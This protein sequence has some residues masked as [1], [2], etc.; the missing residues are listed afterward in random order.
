MNRY[1]NLIR[2]IGLFAISNIALKLISFFLIPLYT[3]QLSTAE[4]GVVDMLNT[5]ILMV[6]PLATLSVCDAVLRYCIEDKQNQ[7]IYATVG[8]GFT[9]LSC[10]IVAA[11]LPILDLHFFGGL[12]DYKGWFLLCYAAIAFQ[13][14][15]SNISRGVGKVSVMATASVLS[16]VTNILAVLVTLIVFRYNVRGVFFSL[17]LGNGV[18]CLYYCFAGRL[19]RYFRVQK[20]EFRHISKKMLIYSLPLIPNSLS[21]WMTQNINRFFITG[22]LGIGISG[23][24][25]AAAK[26]PSILSLIT[27]IFDQAWS[28]S[29]FQEYKHNSKVD[30]FKAIFTVYNAF[31]TICVS[32]MIVF[33][34][35]I[36]HILLQNDFYEGWIYIPALLIAFYYMALNSF[37][38]SVYTSSLKTTYLFITTLV[39]AILCIVCTYFFINWWSAIGACI[40]S[41]IS[42]MITWIL[43]VIHAQTIIP[44]FINRISLSLT[45]IAMI[46]LAAVNTL[47]LPCRVLFNVIA[48][49]IVYALQ[50]Q[51]TVPYISLLKKKLL[52]K[53]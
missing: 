25:A 30:F 2:N 28:L 34:P 43:R 18:A 26:I 16:S 3:V 9:C 38:G 40:A 8:L 6:L 33:S 49:I 4:Y 48:V 22:I 29:A 12:G 11:C 32:V 37:W 53:K 15:F 17:A 46:V 36:A 20:G 24:Y 51:Q 50:L 1:L 27:S 31:L 13:T 47:L 14:L 42:A 39:G 41:A 52:Q 10:G 5:V 44:V 7:T 45:Q 35:Y 23:M 19:Y 21:W